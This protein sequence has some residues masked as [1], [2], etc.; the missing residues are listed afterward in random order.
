MYIF[1]H[2]TKK[3]ALNPYIHERKQ[4]RI[5]KN[6]TTLNQTKLI[7]TYQI[8]NEVNFTKLPSW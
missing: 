6:E 7:E 4:D 2:N 3:F 5:I 1:A 8:K